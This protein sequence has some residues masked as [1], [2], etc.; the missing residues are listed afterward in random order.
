MLWLAS[1]RVG[2]LALALLLATAPLAWAQ[3]EGGALS[4]PER[5]KPLE[6]LVGSWKGQAIPA[7]RPTDGWTERHVWAWVFDHGT[8]SALSLTVEG[9]KAI[10]SARLTP[11]EG[12]RA[13]VLAVQPIEGDVVQYRGTIDAK[14]QTLT[15]E[16]PASTA[17]DQDRVVIRLN[18]NGIRYTWFEERKPRRAPQ[19]KRMLMANLGKEGE[20]FAASSKADSLPR[21]ILTGGAATMTVTHQGKSYPVCCTGCRDEFLANPDKY[22]AK[23]APQ[24]TSP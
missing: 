16:R 20:T 21:C 14:G 24:A 2:L 19:F 9:G 18:Q 15:L 6:P 13:F 11:E 5:L 22:L 10:K 12:D 4:V 7:A 23:M 8:P 3:D 1:H 17:Q